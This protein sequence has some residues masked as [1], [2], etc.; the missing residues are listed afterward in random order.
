M[1]VVCGGGASQAQP[2]RTNIVVLSSLA[3]SSY[4]NN[5][6]MA[7]A[8]AI[9]PAIGTLVFDLPSFCAADPPAIPTVTAADIAGWFNPLNPQGAAQLRQTMGDL[10]GAFL[11]YDLCECVSGPQ[12]TPPAAV[13]TP[14]GQT[15]NPPDLSTL[16][17]QPCATYTATVTLTPGSPVPA[18]VDLP[19]VFGRDPIFWV[20]TAQ[21]SNPN[22]AEDCGFTVGCVAQDGTVTT[23]SG[24]ATLGNSTAVFTTTNTAPN[25]T[26]HLRMQFVA[27]GTTGY[28]YNVTCTL[29][30]YCA[31]QRPGGTVQ[32]CCPPETN[33]DALTQ[34]ILQLVTLIQR[35]TAPFAYVLGATHSAL[36]GSGS[37][38][39]QGLL[40]AKITP[41][42][43]PSWAGVAAGDPDTLW[44]DSWINWGNADGWTA[45]EFLRASPHLSLPPL[46][47]QFTEIGYSF[48]PGL[49]CDVAELQREA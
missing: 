31:G 44:L 32:P 26:D 29:S 8:Y 9:A 46:A 49:I 41:S 19:S 37:I 7:W 16:A 27:A 47:G 42:A 12:P 36:S 38:S 40:G 3:I 10:V 23:Q 34:Q 25:L 24:P 48:A 35:Q 15:I 33:V 5:R 39:V 2:A 20:G 22:A 18:S 6:G 14:A 13:A 1:T 11:W 21:T 17:V 43:I 30:A 4:L 45:R 28:G